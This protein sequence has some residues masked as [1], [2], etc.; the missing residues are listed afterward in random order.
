M[1][2]VTESIKFTNISATTPAFGLKGGKYGIVAVGTW[3][4]G[5]AKLQIQA[6]D[7]TTYLSLR[8]ATDFAANGY[9]A[10][11]LPVG[12]YRVTIATATG[13]YISITSVPS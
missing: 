2:S 11:D 5:T 4:G 7:G 10:T 1:S 9:V 12:Q 3:G 6:G 8:A 13:V